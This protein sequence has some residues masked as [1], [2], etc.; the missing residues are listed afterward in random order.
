MLLCCSPFASQVLTRLLDAGVRPEDKRAYEEMKTSPSQLVTALYANPELSRLLE[1]PS[2]T[3]ALSAAG[4]GDF[5]TLESMAAADRDVER[6]LEL[7]EELQ[8]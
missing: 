7:M 6:A 3:R 4:S 2:V 8:I 1:K 5:A